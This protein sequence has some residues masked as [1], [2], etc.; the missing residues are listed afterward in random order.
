MSASR[1]RHSPGRRAS[2]Y[3][4]G[5]PHRLHSLAS[6]VAEFDTLSG[7]DE[8]TMAADEIAFVDAD[9]ERGSWVVAYVACFA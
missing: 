9:P 5:A 4:F 2:S 7:F 3:R 1:G 6:D 8:T